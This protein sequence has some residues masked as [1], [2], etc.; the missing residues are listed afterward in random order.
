MSR[1]QAVLGD[2]VVVPALD[3][4]SSVACIRSLG[5]RS[6]PTIAASEL[7][8]PPGFVSKY[9]DER[10]A[11]PSPND[12]L[13]AYGDALL[14]LARRN[15]VR[16]I[17]P[18]READVYCLASRRSTFDEHVHAQWPTLDSLRDVQDRVRLFDA[19]EE[20]GVDAPRTELLSEFE[21]WGGDVIVK[22]R[23]TVHAPAYDDAFDVA[24]THHN[25]TRYITDPETIDADA[26][27]AEMGH[28]PLVQEYVPDSDEYAFFALYDR[29]DCVAS[30]QFRQRRGYKYAG[31]P[32]A[33]REAVDV[34]E[35]ADAGRTLLD[36]LDWHGLAMVEFLRNPETGAFELMEVNPRF[37]TSLPFSIQAGVD[38]PYYYWLLSTGYD[39]LES[40]DAS[41]DVGR[42]GHLLRGELLHLHSILFEEYPLVERPSFP[43]TAAQIAASLLRHPTFDYLSL[44][45]PRPFVRDLVN[46]LT[47]SRRRSR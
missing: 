39:S 35:L 34:P 8:D 37:W 43:R 41:Y 22:P 32:S 11:V 36:H 6:I 7:P 42:A 44:D 13:D 21:D 4:A 47:P 16:T 18:V 10:I 26:L 1:D 40:V 15:D 46:A 29:G 27:V 25:S 17:V 45:D 9:C 30:F 38:F 24:H 19:A 28:V 3:A 20:V 14:S 33:F 23:Y 31:G 5:R 12:D 2:R